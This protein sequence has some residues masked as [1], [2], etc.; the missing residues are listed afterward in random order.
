[1]TATLLS[2][3]AVAHPS[4][5]SPVSASARPLFTVP[6]GAVAWAPLPFEPY[7]PAPLPTP[8]PAPAPTCGTSQLAVSGLDAVGATGNDGVVVELTNSSNR[9]CFARNYPRV[10]LLGP[11]HGRLIAASGGFF[12]AAT[13]SGDVSP[14]ARAAFIVSGSW[15][16]SSQANSPHASQLIASLPG[17]GL[18]SVALP[19]GYA[20]GSNALLLTVP[21]SCGVW[22][23]HV[24]PYPVAQPTSPLDPLAALR[25]AILA[26]TTIEI[27]SPLVYVI[28]LS[29]PTNASISLNPC[30]G[31]VQT[32]DGMKTSSFEY[33]LNCA[34]AKPIAPGSDESFV[35]EMPS[36]PASTGSHQVC[37]ELDG[38]EL[39]E[40]P[41]C[42][43]VTMVN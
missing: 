13:P 22:A 24:Y 20:P 38:E 5:S 42:A 3:C 26:P 17:G 37:W 33:E 34:D 18:V 31:Y 19:G 25:P 7:L 28:S 16:C 11:G 12:D 41:L 8:T 32:F 29:N 15:N 2:G 6:A 30:R 40:A 23:T 43:Y 36:Y 4:S 39:N 10:T 21:T 1:M 14:G 9:T 35:I 27:S